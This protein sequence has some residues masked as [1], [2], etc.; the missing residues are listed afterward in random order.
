MPSIPDMQLQPDSDLPSGLYLS[1]SF[2]IT[3]FFFFVYCVLYILLQKCYKI[4]TIEQIMQTIMKNI[5]DEK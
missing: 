5:N 2:K 4:Q 1:T 3:L